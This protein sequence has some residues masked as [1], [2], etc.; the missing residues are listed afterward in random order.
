[1]WQQF[2][3]DFDPDDMTSFI[4][5]TSSTFIL[6]EMIG[7]EKPTTIKGAYYSNDPEQLIDVMVI[8]PYADMKWKRMGEVEG[9]IEFESGKPGQYM[10]VFGN[11]GD[12]RVAKHVTF[13]LHTFEDVV[14]VPE[15]YDYIYDEQQPEYNEKDAA[16]ARDLHAATNN[17]HLC[18]K[19]ARQA[20]TEIKM[21]LERQH[22]HNMDAH[23]NREFYLWML[24][25]ETCFFA[26]ILYYQ[27]IHLKF[28]LDGRLAL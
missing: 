10:F 20:L 19:K 5:D 11:T 14:E 17:L 25:I 24:L 22:S 27:R 8:G 1:M 4:V 13:A 16:E 6:Y 28:K 7:H 15:R 3:E 21:S 18:R 12:S 9:M 2:I 23:K 26:G